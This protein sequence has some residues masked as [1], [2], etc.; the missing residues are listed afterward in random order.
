MN[1]SV[2]ICLLVRDYD[3]DATLDSGQVFRWQ[4]QNASWAGVI[5]KHRVRLTQT[6]GG[7]RA[8]T[9]APVENWNFLNEFLQTEIDLAGVLKT[10]PEDEPMRAAI[11][12]CPG[13]RLLKQDPWEC[14][15]SFILSS[16]KQ[17]VQIRQIISLLCERF[18]AP[19][20]SLAS[21]KG[22]EGRGEEANGSETH[23]PSPQPSPRLGGA[24]E[25]KPRGLHKPLAHLSVPL[26]PLNGERAGVRGQLISNE[27][28][29]FHAFPSAE[30]LARTTETELR[31][32][33][34]GFRAPSLLAAAREIAEGRFD[35]EHI[36]HLPH[37]EARAELMKLRGVGGK[38]ADC[39]LL[40]AYGFDAAFPVDVWIERALQQLYFPR[41]RA[42][43]QRLRHFAATHFG[44]HAGYAQQ[45]LFHY[46]RTKLK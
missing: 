14:L 45:Y 13:L 37:A 22:G 32:C 46:I 11:A 30:R 44:P 7:I 20:F 12:A 28:I 4:R 16:T 6:P 36:R 1:S 26:S 18:G 17:I 25:K 40:F 27:N 33:K 9:A 10:F 41:R 2:E 5:G 31:N 42:S 8:E 15:A 3:L 39:V 43:E 23:I 24:R 29:L 19:V 34:M 21:Q 38:I 35:L